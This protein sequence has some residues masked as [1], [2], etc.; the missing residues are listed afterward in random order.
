MDVWIRNLEP[1]VVRRLEEQ[2]LAEGISR[3]E[4]VRLALERTAARLSPAELLLA[5]SERTPMTEAEFARI[6]AEA[7]SRRRRRV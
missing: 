7:A 6:R 5:R 4:W 2:A 3:Q 1:E